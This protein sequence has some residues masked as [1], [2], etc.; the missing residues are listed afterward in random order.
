MF[1]VKTPYGMAGGSVAPTDVEV[2]PVTEDGT[3]PKRPRI[4]I[5]EVHL[6]VSQRLHLARSEPSGRRP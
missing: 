1:V 5:D 3:P 2:E 6:C 4:E